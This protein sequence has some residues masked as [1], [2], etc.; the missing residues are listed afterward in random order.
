MTR[1]YLA[2]AL[3]C[4][5]T[6]PAAAQGETWCLKSFGQDRGV[7]AFSSG[8]D[9]ANAARFNAFG[10]VCE[11]EKLGAEPAPPRAGKRHGTA[12]RW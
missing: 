10:G 7:C 11:R 4:L 8:Q 5:A 9:C 3:L 2:S 6:L 1:L 12:A